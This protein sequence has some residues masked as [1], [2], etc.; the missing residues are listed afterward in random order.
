[1]ETLEARAMVEREMELLRKEN[2]ELRREKEEL[3]TERDL[4]IERYENM[5]KKKNEIRTDNFVW[6][7][8]DE[9]DLR[10]TRTPIYE[11]LKWDVLENTPGKRVKLTDFGLRREEGVPLKENTLEPPRKRGKEDTPNPPLKNVDTVGKIHTLL[12]K[13]LS[14]PSS[15]GVKKR[16]KEKLNPSSYNTEGGF[17][18]P[19]DKDL[20][21]KLEEELS[22]SD[23]TPIVGVFKNVLQ[24]LKGVT[25][26][27]GEN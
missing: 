25:I 14:T 12:D 20:F 8:L 1:M 4:W 7:T 19:E 6:R 3:R 23:S 13:Y 2:E 16:R 27:F 5:R 10:V 11:V 26:V 17:L 24:K 15:L 9:V 22:D 21:L 18:T